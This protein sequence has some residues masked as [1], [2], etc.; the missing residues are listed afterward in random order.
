[1][2]TGTPERHACAGVGAD[3]HIGSLYPGRQE[4]HATGPALVLPVQKGSGPGSITLSL[5]VM[6][7]ARKARRTLRAQNPERI[8]LRVC[9]ALR[10]IARLRARR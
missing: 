7:A 4:V 2:S 6:N 3:G 9:A 8:A 5:P 1:M 10:R